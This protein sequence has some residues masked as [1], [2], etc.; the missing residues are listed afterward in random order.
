[1]QQQPQNKKTGILKK[2]A[3]FFPDLT[4][5]TSLPSRTT[6][7]SRSKS[8]QTTRASETPKLVFEVKKFLETPLPVKKKPFIIINEEDLHKKD[9][10]NP[11]FYKPFLTKDYTKENHSFNEDFMLYLNGDINISKLIEKNNFP[12]EFNQTHT[13]ILG[14]RKRFPLRQKEFS[15]KNNS[16]VKQA[17]KDLRKVVH[18]KIERRRKENGGLDSKKAHYFGLFKYFQNISDD[19]MKKIEN[20]DLKSEDFTKK[21][22]TH[23]NSTKNLGE[24]HIIK[25]KS[26]TTINF[27]L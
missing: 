27:T 5:N 21:Y 18:Q 12:H 8:R 7:F 22:Y 9:E 13:P 26:K 1:M 6:Q 20:S 11:Y 17:I 2:S 15:P 25:E 16:N 23:D 14:E 19:Y 3:Y 10:E 24:F 4:I